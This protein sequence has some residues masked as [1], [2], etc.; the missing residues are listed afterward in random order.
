MNIHAGVRACIWSNAY[1]WSNA[2]ISSK[3]SLKKGVAS[4]IAILRDHD[5][6]AG[7]YGSATLH[8]PSM[9]HVHAFVRGYNA[10]YLTVKIFHAC[11]LDETQ[12]DSENKERQIVT[13]TG[14][15]VSDRSFLSACSEM[16]NTF[17]SVDWRKSTAR[18][19]RNSEGWHPGATK[20][21]EEIPCASVSRNSGYFDCIACRRARL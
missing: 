16:H 20:K 21:T 15:I 13:L 17:V 9:S 7:M 1:I 6:H 14:M 11:E 4:F 8:P 3:L 12:Q 5:Q 10:L 19:L 2:C 18:F